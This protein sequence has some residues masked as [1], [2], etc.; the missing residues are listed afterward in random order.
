MKS[1]LNIVTDHCIDNLRQ[2][3]GLPCDAVAKAGDSDE[4]QLMCDADAGILTYVWVKGH[5]MPFPDFSV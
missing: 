3:V 5:R 4:L 1:I 2:K